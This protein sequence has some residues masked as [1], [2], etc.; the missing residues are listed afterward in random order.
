MLS[1][2]TANPPAP[3]GGAEFGRLHASAVA[4][5][6]AGRAAILSALSGGIGSEWTTLIRRE[7]HNPASIIARFESGQT[8][9]YS[10]PGVAFREPGSQPLFRGTVYDQLLPTVA[11]AVLLKNRTVELGAVLRGPFHDP[12]SARAMSSAIDRGKGRPSARP[13]P[14]CAA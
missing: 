9:A 2:A 6:P 10:V 12:A 5:D 3:T 11:G 1:G 13:S 7:V 4:T 8:T 14:H